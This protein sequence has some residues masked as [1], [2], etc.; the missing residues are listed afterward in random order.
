MKKSLIRA[1]LAVT[2][3]GFLLAGCGTVSEMETEDGT[4]LFDASVFEQVVVLDFTDE[5]S[6]KTSDESEEA[7]HDE[8]VRIAG[9]LFADKI[10][11]ELKKKGIFKEVTRTETE[12]GALVIGGAITRYQEGNAAVR[13]LIGLGAGSSYFDATVNFINDADG[14]TLGVMKVD[15]NSWVLGGGLA[16][17]QTVESYMNEAARKVAAELEKALMPIATVPQSGS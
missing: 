9:R 4:P 16:A 12:G 13:F 14:A 7:E 11:A 3:L 6:T 5:T 17:T 15:K 2:S 1:T 8:A 10:A